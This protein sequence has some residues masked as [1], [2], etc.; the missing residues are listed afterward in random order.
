MSL[1]LFK[2]YHDTGF[3][4]GVDAIFNNI[5]AHYRDLDYAF[6][7]GKLVDLIG[8]WIEEKRLSAPG[9]APPSTP[10]GPSTKN[11]AEIKIVQAETSE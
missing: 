8:E 6:L 3:D 11:A 10:P 5:W 1:P 7:G 4:T 9:V 2:K